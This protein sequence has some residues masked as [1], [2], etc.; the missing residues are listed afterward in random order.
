MAKM[1][2]AILSHGYLECDLA[3]NL[4]LPNPAS[5]SNQ[6]TTSIWR[7]FPMYSV[8]IHHEDL[9]WILYDTGL[10]PGDEKDRLPAYFREAFPIYA[11]EDD[12]IENRLK[13]VGLT[14]DDISLLI[15]SH[16]HWDHIGGVGLFSGTKAGQNIITSGKDYSL[17]VTLSHCTSNPISGGYFKWNYDVEGISYQ[18]VDEDYKI[19]DDI[20]LIT[21][22]GHTP[23]VLGLVLHMKDGTYIFPSDAFPTKA[24]FG[25][26]AVPSGFLYDSIGFAAAAKK[27]LAVQKKFNAKLMFSHD[28]DQFNTFKL[29][30]DFYE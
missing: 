23:N 25:P 26:P 3:Y 7:K 21:L 27:L 4:A 8:L 22:G 29:A 1:K 5:K 11:T 20:E 18:F 6:K 24:N 15:I 2:F 28:I 19:N 9:G 12:Y 14:K 10:N 17:G 16:T 13:S 30:P